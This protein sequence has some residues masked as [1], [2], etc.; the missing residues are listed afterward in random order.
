MFTAP[1]SLFEPSAAMKDTYDGSF[2][3]RGGDL[4]LPC[5]A[6]HAGELCERAAFLVCSVGLL[7]RSVYAFGT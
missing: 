2:P 1:R 5:P 7:R 6:V 3:L 4:G